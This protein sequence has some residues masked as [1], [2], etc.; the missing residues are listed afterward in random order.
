[1]SMPLPSPSSSSAEPNTILRIDLQHCHDKTGLMDCLVH[2]L[3]LPAW[4]GCNWDA[5]ADALADLSWLQ[6]RPQVIEFCNA[7]RL[8]RQ[9]PAVFATFSW[10]VEDSNALWA[11]DGLTITL[12]VPSRDMPAP[13]V[14]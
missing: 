10:I 9:A 3:Q 1:M 4:F 8:A 14:D 13:K 6:P 2:E 11:A 12:Q 7:D 5:L